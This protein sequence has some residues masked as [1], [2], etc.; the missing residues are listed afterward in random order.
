VDAS[1]LQSRGLHGLKASI[2][3]AEFRC[4]R[5]SCSFEGICMDAVFK[6][7]GTFVKNWTP[8]CFLDD[9]LS[10]KLYILNLLNDLFEGR[11]A[12]KICYSWLDINFLIAVIVS[13]ETYRKK[14]RYIY[15]SIYI[16]IDLH[17]LFS[18]YVSYETI[19]VIKTLIS[20]Q[21]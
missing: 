17:I 21:L 19:T 12:V 8:K 7:H 3:Y 16:H 9:E 11:A 14:Y 1:G 15:Y 6:T 2:V 5:Q 18:R 4:I 20:N 13:Y 10:R